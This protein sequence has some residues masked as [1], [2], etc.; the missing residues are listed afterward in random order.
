MNNAWTVEGT[1]KQW[2]DLGIHTEACMTQPETC[3]AAGGTIS[4]W[5]NVTDCPSAG[6]IVSSLQWQST[7][8]RIYCTSSDIGYDT[9]KCNKLSHS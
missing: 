4:L 2:I 1:K 5:V 9:H 8:L 7:G 3:S 6:G